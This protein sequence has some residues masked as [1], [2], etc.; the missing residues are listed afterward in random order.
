L[1]DPGSLGAEKFRVLGLRL[2]NLRDKRKLKR[3]VVTGTAPEE[4][5]IWSPPTWHSISA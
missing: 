1:T 4:G 5:K 3:I 2:R